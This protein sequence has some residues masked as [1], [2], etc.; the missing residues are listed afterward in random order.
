MHIYRKY[1]KEDI[2]NA[3]S[4]FELKILWKFSMPLS[5]AWYLYEW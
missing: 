2:K 4:K 1:S 3:F 5:E